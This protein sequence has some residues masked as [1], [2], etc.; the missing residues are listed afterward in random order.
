[1]WCHH[2]P[3]GTYAVPAGKVVRDES[4]TVRT[5]AR[6]RREREFPVPPE[7]DVTR[8][9]FMGAHIR[10]GASASGRIN[11][12]LYFHDATAQTGHVYV[13]YLGR[14]LT[15]TRSWPTT[16]AAGIRPPKGFP[17]PEGIFVTGR[18]RPAGPSLSWGEELA[19]GPH[20]AGPGR[21]SGAPPLAAQAGP[22]SPSCVLRPRELQVRQCAAASGRAKRGR[23]R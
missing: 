6:W 15:N 14:H 23:S 17:S 19:S 13:G 16:R 22:L 5:N 1:M 4:E 8:S 12:R 18:G 20:P 10:I 2:P 3:S 7:I 11:P 9:L 21:G